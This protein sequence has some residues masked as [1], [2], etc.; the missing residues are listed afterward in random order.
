MSSIDLSKLATTLGDYCRTNKENLL[1]SILVENKSFEHMTP[2]AGIKDEEPIL[3]IDMGNL[4]KPYAK[5]WTPSANAIDPTPRIMKVRTMKVE[6]ELEPL[7][8]EKTYLGHFLREG[9]NVENLPFERFLMDKIAQKAKEQ[10]ETAAI[11]KGVYNA[12]GTA[13]AD[14]MDGLNKIVADEITATNIAP[15]VTG[16]ITSSTAVAQLE[17]LFDVVPEEWRETDFKMFVSP[18]IKQWYN[19]DYRT[20][21]GAVSHNQEFDKKYIEGT[22]CEIVGMPGLAG[23]QRIHLV[24]MWNIFWGT[25]LVSDMGTV[26]VERNHWTLDVMMA[27]KVG[28]QIGSLQYYWCNDQV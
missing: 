10:I 19:R 17:S 11:F 14:T 23:S 8:Y 7:K 25:D 22:R 12:V 20:K 6:I 3:D 21:F 16:V 26:S 5:A 9:T 1:Q 2:L 15:T 18:E 27:F 4:I 24:P 13:P 28:V